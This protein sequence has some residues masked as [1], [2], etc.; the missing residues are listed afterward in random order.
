MDYIIDL[1][2]DP[3]KDTAMEKAPFDKQNRSKTVHRIRSTND[4]DFSYL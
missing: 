3:I 4:K 1:Y 2:N